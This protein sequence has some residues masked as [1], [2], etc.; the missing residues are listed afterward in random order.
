MLRKREGSQELS[1]FSKKN[2]T[3]TVFIL[4]V[5][6]KK[7]LIL[8]SL[9]YQFKM[10]GQVNLV[11]NPSFEDTIQCVINHSQFQGYVD[12]WRG[13]N[14]EYFNAYCQGWEVEVP[15]NVWGYCPPRTGAAYAGIYCTIVDNVPVHENARDVIEAPLMT[16]L[17]NG[18]K[19][20][21]SFYVSL[22]DSVKY[23]CPIGFAL[24]TD[25]ADSFTG[26]WPN[27]PLPDYMD[28]SLTRLSDTSNWVLVSTVYTAV[29]NERY[30]TIGNFWNDTITPLQIVNGN[31]P[32]QYSSCYF[33]IDD[34]SVVE[35]V[36]ADANSGSTICLTDSVQ[37][38]CNT[39]PGLNYSW[40]P[41]AFL[42][43]STSANPFAFPLQTTTYTLTIAD[44]SGTYCTGA[45]TDTLTI[46][47]LDCSVPETFFVPTILYGE[48]VLTISG[49]P[50]NSIFTLHDVRGRLIFR[51][52]NYQNDLGV[53]SLASGTYLYHLQFPNGDIQSGKVIILR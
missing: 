19:Y 9:L 27:L 30:I 39:K 42:S 44:T 6:I 5:L 10:N 46:F 43:D 25:T 20:C 53:S 37:I 14:G 41:G 49:I 29:G 1:L 12:E 11:L 15:N 8:L 34:V 2:L 36:Q 23:V 3:L 47:V 13:G 21:V 38:T 4:L 33:H 32:A 45:L 18:H 35:Y 7:W 31:A 28:T 17:I 26:Y 40:S 50:Q 48:E 51:S 16:P 24:T 22:S 52:E